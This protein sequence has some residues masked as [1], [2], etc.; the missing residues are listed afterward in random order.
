VNNEQVIAEEI[1]ASIQN[2]TDLSTDNITPQINDPSHFSRF[3]TGVI[4]VIIL[5]L[6]AGGILALTSM[7]TFLAIVN[8]FWLVIFCT[9]LVFLIL[10]VLIMVGLKDQVK[11]I[12]DIFVEGTLTIVNLADF[13][14]LVWQYTV[15][16]FQ[17]VLYFM[18]PVFAYGLGAVIYFGLLLAYKWIGKTYDVTLFTIF[19]A[20]VM[21][22]TIGFLNKPLK[23][24]DKSTNPPW[25]KRIQLRFKD[26][27][28]DAI[29][30]VLFVFFMTM[31]S[32]K[33]LFLPAGLGSVELH[34]AFNGY[35]FMTRGWHFDSELKTTLT[36]VMV[37]VMLEVIRFVIRVIFD[38]FKFY[39]DINSYLG[40]ANQQMNGSS[41]IKWSLR[42]SFEVHKDDSVR[43]ITYT[44]FII[45]VFLLFP[46]LKL[47]AMAV[48][49]ISALILDIAMRERLVIKR[50]H[51][52]FSKLVSGIFHV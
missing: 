16:M 7:E 21:T 25:L 44:T 4:L 31:D 39:K 47:L 1:P 11:Q 33:L 52:L 3:I 50:G 26:L 6:A 34:S 45:F 35:N 38:G 30:V 27:F 13:I 46:R 9:V 41:Q 12:L 32:T 37:A 43:F 49:S 8:A 2:D 14:K 17:Q 10:G 15:K 51:D 19:L 36:L 40:E 22:F 20:A 5:I 23:T 42:Q 18:V 29:E 28:S 48:A 24:S